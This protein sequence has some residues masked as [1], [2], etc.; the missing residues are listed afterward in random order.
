MEY[1]GEEGCWIV[2]ECVCLDPEEYQ[3]G[4]T[5]VKRMTL[6][7]AKTFLGNLRTTYSGINLPGGAQLNGSEILQQGNSEQEA[8][9]AELIQR[10]PVLSMW[11]G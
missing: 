7:K 4:E 6:A 2:S 11:H 9:R 3:Y 5:W 1:Q 8:L 10:F